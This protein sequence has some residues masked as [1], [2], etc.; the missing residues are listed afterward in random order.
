MNK[1]I[2]TRS[3]EDPSNGPFEAVLFLS[4]VWFFVSMAL[5]ACLGG[6][7]NWFCSFWKADSND[8]Y[9]GLSVVIFVFLN[10]LP[11]IGLL[12]W[13]LVIICSKKEDPPPPVKGEEYFWKGYWSTVEDS[14]SLESETESKS[15]ASTT[16][17]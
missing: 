5:A 14:P 15:P 12:V 17:Q 1:V 2:I 9:M 13:A 10:F 4:A 11:W 8:L 3:Y 6:M 16:L 7:V